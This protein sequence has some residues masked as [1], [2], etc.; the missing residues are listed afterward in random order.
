MFG[1]RESAL[2]ELCDEL[3]EA[4][5]R[6][7]AA[8]AT[9]SHRAIVERVGRA[10]ADELSAGLL[11]LA[12]AL[13]RVAL[14]NGTTLAQLAAGLIE[15]GADPLPVLDVLVDRVATGLELAAQFAALAEKLGDEIAAPTSADEY[16]ALRERVVAAAPDA[17]LTAEDAGEI[18]QAWFTVNDW[19][20]ALLVPLQQKEVRQALPDRDR[21]TRATAAMTEHAADAGWLLGLL[22]VLD[23]EPLLVLHRPSGRAYEVTISGVGDNFQL[24]TLLAAALIG[25]PGIGLIPGARPHPAWTAAATNGDLAPTD[26]VNGQFNLV[27]GRGAWIWNAGRPS[28]IPLL[29]DHRVVVLDPPPYE[30]SWNIGRTY[31][32]MPPHV[33]LDRILGADEAAA[34]FLRVAP[35]KPLGQ[36]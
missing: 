22:L 11:R 4:V 23:D 12:P 16:R 6:L 32:L 26:G 19:I 3:G 13:E 2:P 33:T 24:H 18:T 34:W 36:S 1:R 10:D 25:D 14:G 27:D 28:D 5:L 21:L 9:R 31:P 29:G 20:P 8:A 30:R 7:D 17:G 15:I 35:A